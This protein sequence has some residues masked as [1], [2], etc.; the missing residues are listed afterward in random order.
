MKI[1]VARREFT[2]VEC[3]INVGSLGK[4]EHVEAVRQNREVCPIHLDIVYK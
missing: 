4:N 1:P 2:T 3:Y